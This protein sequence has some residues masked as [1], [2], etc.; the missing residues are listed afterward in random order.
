MTTRAS[1]WAMSSGAACSPSAIRSA[2]TTLGIGCSGTGVQL[3]GL[4]AV[5]D[6]SQQQQGN[7]GRRV[8]GVLRRLVARHRAA[9]D[10]RE[11]LGMGDR[12]LAHRPCGRHPA[13]GVIGA[14][15]VCLVELGGRADGVVGV[16]DQ[17]GQQLVA[18]REVAVDRR[19]GHVHLAGD[20]AQRERGGSDLGELLAGDG[21][22]LAGELGA[23][24]GAGAGG[25]LVT[26][27]ARTMNSF[28][29]DGKNREH[30]S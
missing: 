2:R 12:P 28:Q 3:A 7:S 24:S 5:V 16:D 11:L 9:V 22:D 23:H 8:D 14:A 21:L 15:N 6:N 1:W 20:G 26:V 10:E 30:C 29:S 25:A 18:A 4:G 13:A 17:R 27:M 19:G